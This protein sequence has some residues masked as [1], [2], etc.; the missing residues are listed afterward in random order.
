[1]TNFLDSEKRSVHSLV[2]GMLVYRGTKNG[3]FEF[4]GYI[5]LSPADCGRYEEVTLRVGGAFYWPFPF[6]RG[7]RCCEVSIRV[8]VWNVGCCGEVAVVGMWPLVEVPLY[9]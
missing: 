5:F 7:G 1:M 3:S 9:V 4:S 2:T 6:S 8:N